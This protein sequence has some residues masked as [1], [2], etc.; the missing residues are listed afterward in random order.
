[1]RWAGPAPAPHTSRSSTR[2]SP[3]IMLPRSYSG[4]SYSSS[5][6]RSWLSGSSRKISPVIQS[7][8]GAS[9][10]ENGQSRRGGRQRERDRCIAP[11][12]RAAERTDY[13]SRAAVFRRR[14]DAGD[15]FT[16]CGQRFFQLA[17]VFCRFL[18][19]RGHQVFSISSPVRACA[20]NASPPASCTRYP[21]TDARVSRSTRA[22]PDAAARSRVPQTARPRSPIPNFTSTVSAW[23]IEMPVWSQR[24]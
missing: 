7:A 22:V 14:R 21:S 13:R 20:S 19:A 1:M 3:A 10:R 12:P 9:R 5:T 23:R 17:G 2:S 4:P 18:R 8:F 11:A 16:S 24:K 6:P 15:Q